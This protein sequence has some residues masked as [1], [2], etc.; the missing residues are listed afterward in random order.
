MKAYKYIGSA[1][2]RADSH[3]FNRDHKKRGKESKNT[4]KTYSHTKRERV[5]NRGCGMYIVAIGI[6]MAATVATAKAIE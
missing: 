5:T 3:F 2:A 1:Y 6:T 4:Q